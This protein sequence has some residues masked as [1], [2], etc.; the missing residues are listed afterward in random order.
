MPIIL[1][2]ILNLLSL[3]DKTLSFH[4]KIVGLIPSVD[5]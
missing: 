4:D 5:I 3:I 2:F 1:V